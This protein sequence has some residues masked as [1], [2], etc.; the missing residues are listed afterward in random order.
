MALQGPNVLYASSGYRSFLRAARE[1]KGMLLECSRLVASVDKAEIVILHCEPFKYPLLYETYPSLRRKYVIGCSTWEADK[2]PDAF[3]PG[4]KLV[5]EV[6]TPSRYCAEIFGAVHSNIRIIPHVAEQ[7]VH[8]EA[9]DQAIADGLIDFKLHTTYYLLVAR[10]Q[11]PRKNVSFTIR[12]FSRTL[13]NSEKH[14]LIVKGVESD[15]VIGGLPR[16]VILLRDGLSDA[17]ISALY[18]RAS[19][20]VSAHHSE[21]WGFGMS[22]A[23]AQGLPVIATRYSGNLEYLRDGSSFLLPC[24][25]G[26][27]KK[28]DC[29]SLF[30][31]SMKWAYPHRD[32]LCDAFAETSR[33]S[34]DDRKALALQAKEAI[35]PFTRASVGSIIQQRVAEIAT[36]I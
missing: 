14:V 36:S 27:I 9:A 20:Y 34:P 8:P 6:W 16:N 24:D 7:K 35:R 26:E 11:D 19:V 17:Q 3:V 5:Q 18:K 22:D 2:L 21:G 10:L 23:V 12:Q 30:E 32:A 29:F 28:E 25:V 4:L 33:M 13:G 1:Q 15:P 31:S